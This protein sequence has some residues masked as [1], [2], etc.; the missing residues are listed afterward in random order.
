M[1]S[2]VGGIPIWTY[3]SPRMGIAC[4]AG[5]LLVVEVNPVLLDSLRGIWK[6]Q[7]LLEKGFAE[8]RMIAH[9]DSVIADLVDIK[10]IDCVVGSPPPPSTMLFQQKWASF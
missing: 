7:G 5:K 8:S 10:S 3:L 6:T 1:S 2:P 9:D 4:N